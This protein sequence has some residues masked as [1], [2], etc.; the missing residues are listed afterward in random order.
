MTPQE[1]AI[2]LLKEFLRRFEDDNIEVKE[3]EHWIY[4]EFQMKAD[5]IVFKA[6]NGVVQ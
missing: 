4:N 3:F 1:Q 5:S 2:E 6:E